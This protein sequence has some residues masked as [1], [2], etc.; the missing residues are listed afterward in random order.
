MPS[1]SS[2]PVLPRPTAAPARRR[3]GRLC[4]VVCA[5]A[6][7]LLP[8]LPAAAHG[9]VWGGRPCVSPA[10]AGGNGY[11]G[12]LQFALGSWRAMGGTAY[13]P[14]ADR[15][16]RTWQITV[17]RR[18]LAL[19]GWQAWPA[20]AARLGLL[21]SGSRLAA[22]MAPPRRGPAAPRRVAAGGPVHGAR[23]QQA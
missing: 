15:A 10:D 7:G 18:L 22:Q 17:A 11:F 14:C 9:A 19:R 4:T 1:C 21:A 13:A 2:A 3:P 5:A 23:R 20:C 6:V 16:S 12:G 8:V